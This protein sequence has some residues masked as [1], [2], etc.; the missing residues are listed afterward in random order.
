MQFDSKS[1]QKMYGTKCKLCVYLLSHIFCFALGFSRA[2]LLPP[3]L[4]ADSNICK[5]KTLQ[6]TSRF[7]HLGI[8]SLIEL[9]RF[10]NSSISI[11][12]IN[13]ECDFD[14]HRF[15]ENEIIRFRFHSV[16]LKIYLSISILRGSI[17]RF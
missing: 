13:N 17:L 9:G 16:L 2:L 1:Y 6:I 14:S 3:S 10:Q 8:A 5:F 15:F 11:L 7:L 12:Y 4:P